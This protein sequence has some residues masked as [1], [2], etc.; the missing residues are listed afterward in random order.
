MN[1]I[2]DKVLNSVKDNQ[3][4]MIHTE[5]EGIEGSIHQL[6]RT[7]QLIDSDSHTI[8]PMYNQK[9]NMIE[10]D[11][12]VFPLERLIILGGG[13][14]ALPLCD[15]ASKCGFNVYV[16]DDRL[17]F[18]NKERFPLAKE[19][20][21]NT[22]ENALNDLKIT[23]YDY[24]VIITRGHKHDAICLRNLLVNVE[25]FYLGMIGSKR[26]VKGLLDMLKKEGYDKNRIDKIC[27]PI[28]LKIGAITPEEISISILSQLIAYKHLSDYNSNHYINETDLD[29]NIIEYLAVNKEPKSIVTIIYTKGSTPRR[30]GAKM[31]VNL[32]G[33]TIG[34]IGGGCSEG[35]IIRDAIDIIGTRSYKVVD[36]DMSGDIAEDDGMVCGGSMKV[37]I[38]DYYE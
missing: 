1:N 9:D 33:K 35:A 16:V 2:Y 6:K 4:V 11:E 7:I 20:I 18:A 21:C 8:K 36:I 37:L 19:V 12:P 3:K 30:E 29:Y 17:D 28:G 23:S 25:P 13:H 34:S 5:L 22:F 14:I 31:C 27:S 24:V 38:E 10:I 15:F 26:R 32:H